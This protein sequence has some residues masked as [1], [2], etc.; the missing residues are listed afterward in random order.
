MQQILFYS[1]NTEDFPEFKTLLTW[2]IE[3]GIP[4]SLK[5]AECDLKI[6]KS[7][8]KDVGKLTINNS[9]IECSV[10][11]KSYLEQKPTKIDVR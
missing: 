8:L 1:E 6:H 2:P 10:T 4:K 11:V 5:K 3:G 7:V 9:Q